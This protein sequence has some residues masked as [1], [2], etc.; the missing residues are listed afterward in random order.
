M[1]LAQSRN[2][3]PRLPNHCHLLR[4]DINHVAVGN[5]VDEFVTKIDS[6]SSGPGL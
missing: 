5:T 1:G 4:V 6:S 2:A 3:I